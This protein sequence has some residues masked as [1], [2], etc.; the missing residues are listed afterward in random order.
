MSYNTSSTGRISRLIS[1]QADLM[2]KNKCGHYGNKVQEGYCS[3]CYKIYKQQQQQQNSVRYGPRDEAFGPDGEAS[4]GGVFGRAGFATLPKSARLSL[5]SLSP[6]TGNFSKFEEKKKQ[7][8]DRKTKSFRSVF[9]KS[10]TPSSPQPGKKSPEKGSKEAHH[11]H[12]SDGGSSP[13]MSPRKVANTDKDQIRDEINTFLAQITNKRIVSDVV[14]KVKQCEEVILELL[15]QGSGSIDEASDIVQDFYKNFQAKTEIVKCYQEISTEDKELLMNLIEKYLTISLY[16]ELFSPMSTATE[17]ETKDLELQTRIRQLNWMTCKHLEVALNERDRSVRDLVYASINV[18]IGMDSVKPPQE[19][20]ACVTQCSHHI[21]E[22]LGKSKQGPTAA[23]DFLPTLI[24]I[25]I[26]ANPTRLQ[27]NINYITRF[28]NAAQLMRGEA[29]YFFTNLCCAVSFIQNMKGES[30]GMPEE[31]FQDYMSGRSVPMESWENYFL[32][33]IHA[34][35][36]MS[37]V[38]SELELRQQEFLKNVEKFKKNMK[39]K[40]DRVTEQV[41]KILKRT[42]LTFKPRK[43]PTNID[44]EDPAL[45]ETSLPSPLKPEVVSI[46]GASAGNESSVTLQATTEVE[47]EA[48]SKAAQVVPTSSQLVNLT[49]N[50]SEEYKEG[51]EAE[52]FESISPSPQSTSETDLQQE[53]MGAVLKPKEKVFRQKNQASLID[54]GSHRQENFA[55]VVATS[56]SAQERSEHREASVVPSETKEKIES[57]DNNDA[58]ESS[59][60]EA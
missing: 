35:E 15:R 31:E 37:N 19:K 4:P 47:R 29:G 33:S 53:R 42:P 23:D 59:D 38:V 49:G 50:D 51:G 17:D 18:I 11:R 25:V 9:R 55:A 54:E 56:K 21:I 45:N 22:A 20:L 5:D 60:L 26:K 36:E 43:V 7:Q 34:M 13:Q 12:G 2:C 48:P 58:M 40:E 30:L 46:V 3:V 1:E 28:C 57:V 52:V 8:T 24:Y 10:P 14:S 16:K 27:S 39:D 44:E 41:D 6:L 32:E